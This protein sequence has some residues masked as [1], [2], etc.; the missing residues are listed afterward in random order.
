MMFNEEI[1]LLIVLSRWPSGIGRQQLVREARNFNLL[2]L[3]LKND[4]TVT[5]ATIESLIVQNFVVKTRQGKCLMTLE[6][7][8]EL[9]KLA[10]RLARV[11]SELRRSTIFKE[12]TS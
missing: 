4:T 12:L 1:G 5:N 9:I 2:N 6:G 11:E 8:Q 10:D 7:V 3:G